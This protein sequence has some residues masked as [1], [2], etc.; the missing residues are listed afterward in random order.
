MEYTILVVDDDLDIIEITRLYLKQ[1]GYA[2]VT[3]QCGKEA[4]ALIAKHKPDLIVLDVMMC[5]PT[6]GFDLAYELLENP[7][8]RDI[9]IIM[10]TSMTDSPDYVETFQYITEKPWPVS[11]FLEKPVSRDVLITNVKKFLK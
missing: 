3:A 2:V 11:V 5:T 4:K 7:E 1:E 10:M 9:P 8:T 6:E